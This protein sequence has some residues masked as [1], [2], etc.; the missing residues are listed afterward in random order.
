MSDA[1]VLS[2]F[3]SGLKGELRRNVIVRNISTLEQ[4]IQV[5]KS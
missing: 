5:V 2:R 3:R 4:V 1:I